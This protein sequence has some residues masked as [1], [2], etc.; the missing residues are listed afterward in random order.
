MTKSEFEI[1]RKAS[2]FIDTEYKDF[3]SSD[4]CWESDIR[5]HS[6]K[7]FR[8][9]YLN[10]LACEKRVEGRIIRGEY[11]PQE[12]TRKVRIIEEVYYE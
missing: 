8:I 7:L 9:E 11:E 5:E 3:Y 4:N 10:G 6:G 1:W 12:V 2:K